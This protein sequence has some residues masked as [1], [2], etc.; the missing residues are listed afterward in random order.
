METFSRG[1]RLAAAAGDR[2]GLNSKEGSKLVAV[3][4]GDSGIAHDAEREDAAIM[5]SSDRLLLLL[6]MLL[7]L[8]SRS[9]CDV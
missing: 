9:A 4:A 6:T 7:L 8:R 3:A 1:D 2:G 5:A